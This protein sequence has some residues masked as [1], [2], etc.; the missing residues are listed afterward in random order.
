MAFWTLLAVFPARYM[1]P[2]M[3]VEQAQRPFRLWELAEGDYENA[4]RL[5]P[6]V[7]TPEQRQT[8]GVRLAVIRDNAPIRRIEQPVY[9]RRL[10][11]AM[12][13]WK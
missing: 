5:I 9:K 6:G 11:R 12:E 8:W 4:V 1:V 10:G 13:S 7:W 2:P 3:P